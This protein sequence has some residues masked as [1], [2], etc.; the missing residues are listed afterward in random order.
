M[1][2]HKCCAMQNSF[3]RTLG[4]RAFDLAASGIA[5]LLLIPVLAVVAAAIK[6]SGPGPIIFRHKRV[7]RGFR[8][9][10]V[11]KF[12]TMCLDA[13]K[14]G[15]AV[16]ASGDVRVTRVGKFLRQYKIDELPQFVNILLGDMSL[17]GPR[18]EVSKYV[19]LFRKDYE[20]VLSVRPGLTDYA[21]IKY[22]D[23]EAVLSACGDTESAYIN[24][25]LPDKIALYRKYVETVSFAVDLKLL[26]ATVME[27]FR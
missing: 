5:I 13:D 8:P 23:E 21:A 7:G 15:G 20:T 2:R 19:E 1:S 4:K 22:R 25:I 11:Y 12:R 6:L 3:Y 18:P 17:V 10:F 24:R 27:V 9:F 14:M 26:C 16:T